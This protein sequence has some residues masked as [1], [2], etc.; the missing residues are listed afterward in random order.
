MHREKIK[1]KYEIEM[2]DNEVTG[3]EVLNGFSSHAVSG[4]RLLLCE[5]Y[6]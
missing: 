1:K 2:L 4:V 6:S 5:I 3:Y